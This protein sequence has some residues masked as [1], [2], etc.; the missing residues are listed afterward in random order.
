LCNKGVIAIA[1]DAQG[2]KWFGGGQQ[3]LWDGVGGVSKL[4]F[5]SNDIT[6]INNE[7]PIHLYPNPVQNALSIHFSGKSGILQIY[8]ISGKLLLQKPLT[9]NEGSVDFSGLESGIYIVN[10]MCDSK[11]FTSKIV[12][13]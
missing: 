13:Y 12:K 11:I 1:I 6:S 4:A 9:E 10:V 3:W 7:N 2:N 8:D 5:E